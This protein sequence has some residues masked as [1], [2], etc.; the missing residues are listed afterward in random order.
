MERKE[1]E[2]NLL[3]PLDTLR[4]VVRYPFLMSYENILITVDGGLICTSCLKENYKTIL[5]STK[6]EDGSGWQITDMECEN[7]FEDEYCSHCNKE[8]GYKTEEGE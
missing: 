6:H 2:Y 8:I 1:K 3:D 7:M 5:Y 4:Y